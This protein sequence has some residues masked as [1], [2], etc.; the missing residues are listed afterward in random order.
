MNNY[1][2]KNKNYWSQGVFD[3]PNPETYVFRAYGRIFKFELGLDGSGKENLLDFGCGPGGNTNFYHS[4]GFTVYGVDLSEIDIKRCK[5]RM[6]AVANN[7]KI[8]R[9]E[10]SENDIFFPGISFKIITAFQSIYFYT[11]KDLETRLKSLY[12][13]MDNGGIIYATMMHQSCWYYDM[14]E[15]FE[16]GLRLVKLNRVNDKNRPGLTTNDHYINFVKDEDDLKKKFH[17][18]KPLHIGYYDGVYR[19]DERSEK[20]LT[21]IG[22]KK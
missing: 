16:D 14:S 11:N 12:N 18:F 15:P 17:M 9:P 7:F 3:A 20:H 13:Q 4:K 22:I 8:V 2:E 5:E 10:P 21:F 19:N 6:P 1:H